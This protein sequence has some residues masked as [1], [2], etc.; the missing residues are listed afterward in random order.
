ML[1]IDASRDAGTAVIALKIKTAI[2]VATSADAD[3]SQIFGYAPS[4]LSDVCVSAG[5]CEAR[6]T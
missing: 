2:R 4:V 1:C 3:A 5:F 6:C